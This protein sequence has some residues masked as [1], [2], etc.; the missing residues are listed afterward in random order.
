MVIVVVLRVFKSRPNNNECG[1]ELLECR[2]F[3]FGDFLACFFIAKKE[4]Y[5]CEVSGRF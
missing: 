3:G 1:S 4:C 2:I 5:D